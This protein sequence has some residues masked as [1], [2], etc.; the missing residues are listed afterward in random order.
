M[1]IPCLVNS[2]LFFFLSCVTAGASN[3]IGTASGLSFRWPSALW[4]SYWA[5]SK[6]F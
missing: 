6:C 5:S 3:N 2:F 4:L 1:F